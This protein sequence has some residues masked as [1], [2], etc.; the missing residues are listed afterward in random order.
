M[1]ILTGGDVSR[2]IG[3][4]GHSHNKLNGK[5]QLL[6]SCFAFVTRIM[7][8]NSATKSLPITKQPYLKI[9]L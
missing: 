8:Q 7:G 4:K 1:H 2:K 9:T 6:W 3:K 5:Q